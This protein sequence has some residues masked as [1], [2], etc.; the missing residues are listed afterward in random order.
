M[1]A[2]AHQAQRV[3]VGLLVDQHQ[4]GLDVAIPVILPVPGQRVVAVPRFQR[5]VVGERDQDGHQ[6]GVERGPVLPFRLALVVALEGVVS[7]KPRNFRQPIN[8]A[9]LALGR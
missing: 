5:L 7:R 1:R 3:G 6:V 9:C 8:M 2:E 4:V